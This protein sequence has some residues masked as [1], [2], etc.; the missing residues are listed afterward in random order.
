MILLF[1][2]A[3]LLGGTFLFRNMRL[4]ALAGLIV[5]IVYAFS[6]SGWTDV[7]TQAVTNGVAIVLELALLLFGAIGFYQFLLDNGRLTFLDRFVSTSPN[8]PFL[9]ITYTMFLGSF[10]EG[11]AGFGVPPILLIPLLVKS[12][13]KPITAVVVA[14]SG[15]V[16]AVLFGALGTPLIIGLGIRTPDDVVDAVII[17]NSLVFVAMPFII[18]YLYGVCEDVKIDWSS[19]RTM[20]LGAGVIYFILFVIVSRFTVE[21]PSVIA[22]SIGMVA[23]LVIYNPEVRKW[24]AAFWLQSFWPYAVLIVLLLIARFFLG[25]I[26]LVALAGKTVSAYQPGATFLLAIALISLI[27]RLLGDSS[28]VQAPLR[29]SARRTVQ[30]VLTILLLVVFSQLARTEMVGY[31]SVLIASLPPA[32]EPFLILSFGVLGSFIT[33][34]ATMSNLLLSGLLTGGLAS[35]LYIAMLHSGS[36][37]GNVISLQNIVMARSALEDDIHDR[38]VLHN[39]VRTLIVCF[40][41]VCIATGLWILMMGSRA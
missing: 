33:G 10:F 21:Y 32:V 19:Y 2:L 20:L 31:V 5:Q 3:C 11:I 27:F 14:L 4:G 8:R 35:S 34:S 25:S 13:F 26:T 23:Y 6:S 41:L 16:T 12:G 24:G 22:G 7:H 36:T 15:S 30:S 28:R 29:E 38:D 1:S 39:T 9:L 17:V 37:L 40:V 18:T